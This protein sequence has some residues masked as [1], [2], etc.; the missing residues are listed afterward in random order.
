MRGKMYQATN[1]KA[2]RGGKKKGM[3]RKPGKGDQK[4]GEIELTLT[5]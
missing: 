3:S 1:A 4:D 2:G 5:R